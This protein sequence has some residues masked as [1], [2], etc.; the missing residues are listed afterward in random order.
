MA[1]DIPN[2]WRIRPPAAAAHEIHQMALRE[3]RSLTNMLSTLVLE[4]LAARRR[5]RSV[6]HVREDDKYRPE[7]FTAPIIFQIAIFVPSIKGTC[8]IIDADRWQQ[9]IDAVKAKIEWWNATAAKHDLADKFDYEIHPGHQH[10]VILTTQRITYSFSKE[11]RVINKFAL[12]RD[13]ITGEL[14]AAKPESKKGRLV[15]YRIKPAPAAWANLA[16]KS[17]GDIVAKTK[18]VNFFLVTSSSMTA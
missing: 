5:A 4:A 14:H 1:A 10:D 16:T 3:N 7:F 9:I 18:L 6:S 17:A 8:M 13:R 15:G 2:N 11:P 12:A